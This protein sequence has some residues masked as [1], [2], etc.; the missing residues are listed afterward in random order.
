M[1]VEAHGCP[2]NT[3]C[4]DQW[5]VTMFRPGTGLSQPMH[6][7]S[8]A[9]LPNHQPLLHPVPV[10]FEPGCDIPLMQA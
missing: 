1:V 8:S 9:P 10:L 3:F 5:S 4:W 6:T 2:S 7:S